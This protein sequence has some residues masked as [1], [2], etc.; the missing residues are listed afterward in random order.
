MNAFHS[1]EQEPFNEA[2]HQVSEVL[3]MINPDHGRRGTLVSGGP[4]TKTS[5]KIFPQ[6][7]KTR[8]VLLHFSRF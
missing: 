6:L 5:H 4:S 8:K 7:S 3:H 2:E 1:N